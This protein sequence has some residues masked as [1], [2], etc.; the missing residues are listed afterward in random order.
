MSR[1]QSLGVI[2][3]KATGG[4]LNQ[5]SCFWWDWSVW[6][7]DL[8][9]IITWSLHYSLQREPLIQALLHSTNFINQLLDKE[10][11]MHFWILYI[12]VRT[13]CSC[14]WGWTCSL[15]TLLM[16]TSKTFSYA[17][18]YMP[19]HNPLAPLI[20][21]CHGNRRS[22]GWCNGWAYKPRGRWSHL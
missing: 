7:H 3:M 5:T 15:G 1:W 6:S 20:I 10:R 19:L 18:R 11:K 12:Y 9:S 22:T 13:L 2:A 4:S 16:H 17:E 14:R 21:H 8:L